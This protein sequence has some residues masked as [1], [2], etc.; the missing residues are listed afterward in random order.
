VKGTETDPRLPAGGVDIV[1]MVD[2]YHEL[3]Y[4]YEVISKVRDSLRPGGRV[5]FVEYRKEDP[6]V[7]IKRAHEMTLDQLDKEMAAVG[8]KRAKTIETLPIQHI[9]IYQKAG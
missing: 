5:V 7:P 2:V 8:L 1:L 4:P 9:A 3:A 6:T